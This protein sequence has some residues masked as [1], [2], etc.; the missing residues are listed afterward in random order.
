M[1]MIRLMTLA[2]V[3]MLLACLMIGVT[4]ALARS[5]GADEQRPQPEVNPAAGAA[6]DTY[7]FDN[8]PVPASQGDFVLIN[9]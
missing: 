9:C 1:L 5:A 6:M 8:L 4:I 3:L 7:N 2:T